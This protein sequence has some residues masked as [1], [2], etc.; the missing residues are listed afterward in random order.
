M[1]TFDDVRISREGWE[2]IIEFRDANTATTHLTLGPD[3]EQMTDQQILD[4]FNQTVA[5]TKQMAAGYEHVAI[6]IPPGRPQV[7]YFEPGDQWTPRGHVLR[8]VIDDGGPDGEA[9]V[10]IDDREFS[11]AEFGKLLCT[12]AG[13]GMRITFV[14]EDALDQQPPSQ[15]REPDE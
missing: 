14:P 5:S 12:Y 10:L 2:A 3:I 9:V 1:A 4:Q 15:V 7:E 6:E 8:C 11:L 13:W